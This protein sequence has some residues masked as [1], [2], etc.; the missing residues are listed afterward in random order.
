MK[1]VEEFLNRFPVIVVKF[2]V[3]MKIFPVNFFRELLQN[4]LKLRSYLHLVRA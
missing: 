4:C 3:L 2:P 1:S